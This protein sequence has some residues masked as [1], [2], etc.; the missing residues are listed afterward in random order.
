MT[1]NTDLYMLSYPVDRTGKRAATDVIMQYSTPSQ[2]AEQNP[3]AAERQRMKAARLNHH[4]PAPPPP[5]RANPQASN[6]VGRE[7]QTQRTEVRRDR[8]TSWYCD[9]PGCPYTGPYA[10]GLYADCV[11]GCQRPRQPHYPTMAHGRIE[12]AYSTTTQK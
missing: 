5:A 8:A 9:T 3:N 6:P 4:Q 1:I 12:P 7:T 2:W 10:V 11:L